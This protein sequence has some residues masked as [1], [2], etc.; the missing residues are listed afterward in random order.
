MRINRNFSKA[1]L[2]IEAGCPCL[3]IAKIEGK[4]N[5]LNGIAGA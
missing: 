2:F 1:A 4:I 3:P 5:S